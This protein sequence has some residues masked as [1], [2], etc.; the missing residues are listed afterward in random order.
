M[1]DFIAAAVRQDLTRTRGEC[2]GED[3][4]G[5]WWAAMDG[6]V[7]LVEAPAWR[8]LWWAYG[9]VANSLRVEVNLLGV[10]AA[11]AIELEVWAQ[12]QDRAGGGVRV[13][14]GTLTVPAGANIQATGVYFLLGCCTGPRADAWGVRARQAAGFNAANPARVRA[15]LVGDLCG[16]VPG[17]IVRGEGVA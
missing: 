2:F 12:P 16:C 15:R 4:G 5:G 7:S 13:W 1:P 6:Q 11:D 17:V 3:D 9:R 14:Q 10:E 8:Q